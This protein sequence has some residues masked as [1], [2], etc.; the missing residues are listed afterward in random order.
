M[1]K[2]GEGVLVLATMLAS[3]GWLASKQIVAQLPATAFIGWRFLLA[4]GLLLL[5]PRCRRALQQAKASEIRKGLLLGLLLG[6]GLLVWVQA[7]IHSNRIGEGA[8]IA[9][10]S[11]LLVPPLA[12]L[13][14]GLRPS[15]QFWL[16]APIAL[17]GL[18]ALMA[19]NGFQFE[20]DQLWFLAAALMLSLHFTCNQR[21]TVALPS[22]A[23]VALQLIAGGC[24]GLTVAWYQGQWSL[25]AVPVSNEIWQW[26]AVSVGFATAMRY[27]SQTNAQGRL[28]PTVAAAIMLL[29]PIWTLLLSLTVLHEQISPWQLGGCGLIL[30][31]L[32]VYLL[33]QP[34]ST[35][36]VKSSIPAD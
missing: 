12:W 14:F 16:S 6:A 27:W 13:L 35:Q 17:L 28:T 24:L 21:A 34:A 19:N 22:L 8:F 4:G 5:L 15:R 18:L 23:S 31:S 29:E 26:F 9:S 32:L 11:L 25:L 7:I 2:R 36:A 10:L 3:L 20:S 33:P 1:L 30:A